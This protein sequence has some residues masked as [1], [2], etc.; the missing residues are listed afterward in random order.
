MPLLSSQSRCD[1]LLLQVW[2]SDTSED[3][4]KGILSELVSDEPELRL[5][6]TTPESLRNPSLRG[7]LKVRPAAGACICMSV[8]ACSLQGKQGT[9]AAAGACIRMPVHTFS[10]QEKP[11]CRSTQ[12]HMR[13]GISLCQCLLCWHMCCLQEAYEAGTLLSFAIDE[14]SHWCISPLELQQHMT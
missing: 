2:N 1:A 3:V 11:G 10:L 6:Y 12:Q 14:V 7:Y 13:P 9:C 4:R 8:H 5:L